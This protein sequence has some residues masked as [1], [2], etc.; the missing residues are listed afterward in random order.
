MVLFII[1]VCL[2]SGWGEH[3]YDEAMLIVTTRAKF[4]KTHEI[5]VDETKLYKEIW[6][7]LKGKVFHRTSLKNYQEIMSTGFIINNHDEAQKLNWQ[8]NSFFRNRKCVSVCDFY[9][10]TRPRLTKSASYKYNIFCQPSDLGGKFVFL[11]LSENEYPNL[12]TWQT[13]QENREAWSEVV[14]PYLESGYPDKIPLSSIADVWVIE[15][16][17]KSKILE[18]EPLSNEQIAKMKDE[19]FALMKLHGQN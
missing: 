1:D 10:N 5:V 2:Y 12:I 8:S 9:N 4:M 19:L 11:F 16:I 17:G 18:I 3:V 15:V 14:V 6:P 13:W 7:K